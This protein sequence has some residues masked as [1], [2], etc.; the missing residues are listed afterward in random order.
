M[1]RYAMSGPIV[2]STLYDKIFAN[3]I[4]HE[5]ENGTYVLYIGIHLP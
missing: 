2:P 3:H 1:L 4:V 5:Y